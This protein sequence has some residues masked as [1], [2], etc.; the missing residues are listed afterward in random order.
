MGKE[1]RGKSKAIHFCENQRNQREQKRKSKRVK[2][3]H[4]K[5][6]FIIGEE[7]LY[8]KIY[9]GARTADIVLTESIKPL[10]SE[11][12]RAK[13]IDK[14]FFIRY[15]DP[16]IHIR[17]RLHFDNTALIGKVIDELRKELRPYIDNNAVYKIQA[18]TYQRELERYGEKSIVLAE[19]LFYNDSDFIVRILEQIDDENLL[20]LV[21]LKNIDDLL[22]DF[23]FDTTTKIAFVN[24][25]MHYYKEE[26]NAD[27]RT[28][29]Q[30]SQKYRLQA[31]FIE[32]YLLFLD[33][34]KAYTPL[35]K[36]HQQKR[37]RDQPII[38]QVVAYKD[39]ANLSVSINALLGSLIHMS[40]NR[41][42]RSKQRMYEMLLYDFL[43]R[44]YRMK[45]GRQHKK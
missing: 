26:F 27:K 20:I 16:E 19:S 9:C 23:D 3:K 25:Q 36:L 44:Y 38:K 22:T 13:Q 1:T 40:V 21:Q 15:T 14:W 43:L 41:S 24:Q 34:I 7:W 32:D 45:I 28:N 5:R 30:L 29:K 11:L 17:L 10:L 35:R 2:H 42:F 33:K 8:Y 39:N 31:K 6:T 12:V 4:M 37:K 18:D